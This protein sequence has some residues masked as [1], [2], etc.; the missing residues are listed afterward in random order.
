MPR[1]LTS[2]RT[3]VSRNNNLLYNGN[4]ESKP[5]SITA[6]TSTSNKWIDG[7]SGG[8]GAAKAYGW[9]TDVLAGTGSGG[10]DTTIFNSGAASLKVSTLSS[11]S[12]MIV[13]LCPTG[14][15]NTVSQAM[16][17]AK[18]STA[19]TCV[20][21]MKTTVN[22]GAAT[23]GAFLAVRTL[24]SADATIA[25]TTSTK[26]NTTTGWTKYTVTLTTG[27][28]TAY[29]NI[30]LQVTGNNGTGTLVMDAWYDD[31]VL[32]QNSLGR[33]AASGRTLVT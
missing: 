13:Q 30:I 23:D 8:S 10:F 14:T 12:N 28:T 9:R 24:T 26:V 6:A 18:P 7:T 15:G 3:A 20:F 32:Y 4:F 11:G 22:S 19:Y 2:A 5:S 29:I 25:T 27:G 21:W 33:S 16:I 31:I 17:P 1:T